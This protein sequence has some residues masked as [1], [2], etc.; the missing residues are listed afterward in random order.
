MRAGRVH[1]AG[2]REA[3]L[4]EALLTEAFDATVRV[5]WDDGGLLIRLL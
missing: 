2:A 3:V 5:T 4:T 1:A